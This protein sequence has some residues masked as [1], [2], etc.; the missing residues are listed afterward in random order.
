MCSFAIVSP[1]RDSELLPGTLEVNVRNPP[2]SSTSCQRAMTV[3]GAEG[4]GGGQRNNERVC[5]TV[6]RARSLWGVCRLSVCQDHLHRTKVVCPALSWERG[7]AQVLAGTDWC[8]VIET[9][10]Q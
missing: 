9:E 7:A 2:L 3:T 5:T 6:L 8:F 10:N 4:G 1:R